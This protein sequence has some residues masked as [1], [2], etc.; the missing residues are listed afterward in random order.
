M[1][2]CILFL[3]SDRTQNDEPKAKSLQPLN[4][5]NVSVQTRTPCEPST[6]PVAEKKPRGLAN[7]PEFPLADVTVEKDE[8]KSFQSPVHRSDIPY[9]RTPPGTSKLLR[10]HFANMSLTPKRPHI[11]SGAVRIEPAASSTQKRCVKSIVAFRGY[12][13]FF[14]LFSPF[15][16]FYTAD[17]FH[18]APFVWNRILFQNHPKR[19]PHGE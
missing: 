19:R 18:R 16:V 11:E 10:Q 7:R 6:P 14:Y 13:S 5:E 12:H 4:K 8:P 17:S 15:F 1:F 3:R 9:L 2:I